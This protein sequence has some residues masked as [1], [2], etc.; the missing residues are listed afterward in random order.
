M[1]FRTREADATLI[2][3]AARVEEGILV[4]AYHDGKDA[5]ERTES[6]LPSMPS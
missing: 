5:G 4:Y 2:M 6:A 1:A 3:L